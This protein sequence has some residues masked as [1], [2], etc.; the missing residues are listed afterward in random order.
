VLVLYFTHEGLFIA[1]DFYA[2]ERRAGTIMPLRRSIRR[3][4]DL[5]AHGIV[6]AHNHPSGDAT[7]SRVDI[8]TTRRIRDVIEALD[9]RFEDH[10]IV[11]RRRV[12]SMLEQGLI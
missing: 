10:C 4:F 2:G 12:T 5:D 7:P 9:F 3:A 8:A 11:S 1:E 6:L